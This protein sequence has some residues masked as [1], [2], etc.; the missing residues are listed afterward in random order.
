MLITKIPLANFGIVFCGVVGNFVARTKDG[1]NVKRSATEIDKHDV[2][3][4][5][6]TFGKY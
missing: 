5:T 4:E 6:Q 2:E 3:K 1:S